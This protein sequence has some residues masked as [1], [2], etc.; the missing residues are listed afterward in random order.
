MTK[1]ESEFAACMIG[2]TI[3]CLLDKFTETEVKEML[4]TNKLHKIVDYLVSERRIERGE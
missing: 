1:D 3:H 4:R 2:T